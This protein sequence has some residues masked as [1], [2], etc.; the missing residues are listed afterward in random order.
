MGHLP[1]P[2]AA[3]TQQSLSVQELAVDADVSRDRDLLGQAVMMDPQASATLTL[4]TMRRLVDD[5]LQ[6]QPDP[7]SFES[8]RLWVFQKVPG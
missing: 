7:A 2:V 6:Q 1:T 4:P 5:L 8:R 3:L